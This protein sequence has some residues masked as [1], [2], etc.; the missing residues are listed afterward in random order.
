L[1]GTARSTFKALLDGIPNSDPVLLL[2]VLDEELDNLDE[3]VGA[4]FGIGRDSRIE[5]IKPTS[6]SYSLPTSS[7]IF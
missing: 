6:A 5:L 2:G 1:Q 4:W 7:M 3:D